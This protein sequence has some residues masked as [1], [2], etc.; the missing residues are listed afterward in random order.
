MPKILSPLVREWAP[1]AFVVSFKLET[2]PDLLVV[3]ARQAL[4]RYGHQLVIGNILQTR[5]HVVWF[6]SAGTVEEMRA[7]QG[8]I[9]QQICTRLAEM[10]SQHFSVAY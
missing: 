6:I 5:K 4:K 10:H 7:A 3:K 9:E 1:D 2:D 8:D